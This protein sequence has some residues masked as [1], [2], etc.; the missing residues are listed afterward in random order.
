[1][2]KFVK[3]ALCGALAL[4]TCLSATACK[5]ILSNKNQGEDGVLKIYLFDGGYGMGWMEALGEAFESIN[6]G[7]T[8]EITPNVTSAD[9]PKQIEGGAYKGDIIFS[10]TEMTKYGANGYFE[11]LTELMNSTP[12]ATETKTIKEKLG[13][14][15]DAS[16]YDGKY[17]Q[18]PWMIGRTGLFYNKTSLDTIF[19]AG[20]YQLPVTTNELISFCERIKATGNG[21]G[22]VHTNNTDAEYY[23]F[24]REMLAVQYMG[25]DAWKDYF[26]GY[27]TNAA[28]ERVFASDYNDLANAWKA[29]KTSAVEVCEKVA[30]TNNG[31]A[32]KSTEYMD[33]VEAQSYFWGVTPEEWKP[34]AFMVNGDWLWSE[35]E[36]LEENKAAD[37][38][39]M[40]MPIN[41]KIIDVLDTVNTEEQLVE[42]VKYVDAAMVGDNDAYKPTYLSNED[43]LK[44]DEARRLVTSSHGR[45]TTS[46]PHN[47]YNKDLAKAFI[48]FMASDDGCKI[49]SKALN[50]MSTCFSSSIVDTASLNNFVRS[51][52]EVCEKDPI[53]VEYLPSKLT[54]LGTHSFFS[55]HYFNSD[56]ST[57]KKTA[58]DIVQSVDDAMNN[59]WADVKTAAGVQ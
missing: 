31:Y 29:A 44:L 49:V 43:Y 10:N 7:I 41:S 47:S 39:M 11:D 23:I 25:Y 3:K 40:K 2:K 30:N 8:V 28:G 54:I 46:I 17:Y 26:Q 12:N 4:S 51:V 35:V 15:A 52:N 6:P 38:R 13:S 22:F 14:L 57:G 37:I 36:Y 32:P 42:C 55:Y 53:Y 19:G 34:T 58:A 45:H 33:F 59:K 24:M 1:M 9:T 21:W 48:K 16:D 20:S 50:G 18:I 5:G 56:I 27:Y